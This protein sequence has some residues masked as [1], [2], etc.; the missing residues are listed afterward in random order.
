MAE[1][2]GAKRWR[3]AD[4]TPLHL[5]AKVTTPGV[6]AQVDRIDR[7]VAT[8]QGESYLMWLRYDAVADLIEELA[9]EDPSEAKSSAEHRRMLDPRTKLA[10]QLGTEMS[11][12]KK[13]ADHLLN[14]SEAMR[15]RVP[16]CGLLLRDGIISPRAF[17]Q[18]V[19]ET[20]GVV[21]PD[22]LADID[23]RIADE[24][25]GSGQFAASAVGGIARMMVLLVDAEGARSEREAAKKLKGVRSYPVRG[26][27]A[28]LEITDSAEKIAMAEAAVEDRADSTPVPAAAN[29]STPSPSTSSGSGDS[30]DPSTSSGSA[31]GGAGET[32]DSRSKGERRADAAV[33]LLTGEITGPGAKVVVHVVTDGSTLEGGDK[34]GH[35]DGHGAIAADQVRDIAAQPG[36]A[37]RPLDLTDL[38]DQSAQDGNPYRPTAALD[39]T[40]RALFGCCTWPGCSRPAS[41]CQL[42]HVAEF[43]HRDPA[44]GGATCWCN[45][46]PKCVFHHM[47]KTFGEGWLDDQIVDANGEVWT[48]VTT[49][50]GRTHRMRAAN[51][52][53]LPSLGLLPCRHGPPMEPGEVDRSRE[54]VRSRTR[55]QAK[56]AYRQQLRAQNRKNRAAAAGATATPKATASEPAAGQAPA[57]EPTVDTD[58]PPF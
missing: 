11:I 55:T 18:I 47:V 34:P 20:E 31:D 53:L 40:V 19:L 43:N 8:M 32:V 28:V 50:L 44:S 24:V 30:Q 16:Q 21:D 38:V 12:C 2:T 54:P 25:R 7:V 23:H 17:G 39:V 26:G 36:S 37:V 6:D 22:R 51:T 56:H 52:W 9:P 5:G 15:C 45:M 35:L 13:A 29:S 27:M 46:N 48:E 42:D 3:N 14:V 10:A 58:R 1:D 33:G 57:V 41:R 4:L 49:P